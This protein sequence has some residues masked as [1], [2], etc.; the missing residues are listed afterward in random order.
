M[1]NINLLIVF[2]LLSLASLLIAL[3]K[4]GVILQTTMGILSKVLMIIAIVICSKEFLWK[5][6]K[7]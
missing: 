6:S 4:E 3:I 5:K 7:S 1:K 2:S